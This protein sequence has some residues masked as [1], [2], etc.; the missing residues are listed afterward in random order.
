[1]ELSMEAVDA[2]RLTVRG[3]IFAAGGDAIAEELRGFN[4]A[5]SDSPN[6]V[7]GA[8]CVADVQAAI[9]FATA[10]DFGVAVHSTGHGRFS[11]V[12]HGLVITTWRMGRVVVGSKAEDRKDPSGYAVENCFRRGSEIR[13]GTTVRILVVGWSRWIPA[14]RRSRPGCAAVRVR[15]RLRGSRPDGDRRRPNP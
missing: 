2:L 8:T 14:R 12:G 5:V 6:L 11:G 7:V 3:P 13:V 15:G 10:N 4:T 9:Q 1:M